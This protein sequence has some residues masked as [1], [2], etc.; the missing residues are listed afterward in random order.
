[1][2]GPFRRYL[3]RASTM[4]EGLRHSPPAS[5]N[6]Q[7]ALGHHIACLA[8][9][10][11]PR[12]NCTGV[13]AFVS[14]IASI[15]SLASQSRTENR[16]RCLMSLNVGAEAPIPEITSM[17]LR[18]RCLGVRGPWRCDVSQVRQS[19][20]ACAGRAQ[21]NCGREAAE[22]SQKASSRGPSFPES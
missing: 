7:E 13:S 15:T 21:W 20:G 12:I 16:G 4:N 1:V 8:E 22:Q 9:R 6:V 19:R 5:S 14:R 3:E 10:R 2:A 18:S 17:Q 11:S